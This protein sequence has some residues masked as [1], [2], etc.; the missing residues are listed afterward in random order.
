MQILQK[1]CESEIK[2]KHYHINQAKVG[3]K[4]INMI[5]RREEVV[6]SRLRLGHTGLN[7]TLQIIGKS[8]GLCT[9]SN[10]GRCRTGILKS[11]P[12]LQSLSLTLNKHT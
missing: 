2:P 6:Y 8:Y 11:G 12:L 9:M 10:Q 1:E 3:G 7:D 4:R 5:N